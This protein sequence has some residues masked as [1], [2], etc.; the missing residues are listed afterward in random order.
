MQLKHIISFETKASLSLCKLE[1]GAVKCK[2]T[3]LTLIQ[4]LCD[5][6]FWLSSLASK[7]QT[8]FPLPR[9]NNK[10]DAA[11]PNDKASWCVTNVLLNLKLHI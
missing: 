11:D 10:F 4:K 6:S 7:L 9:Q 3:L 1:L 2:W 8:D 5:V